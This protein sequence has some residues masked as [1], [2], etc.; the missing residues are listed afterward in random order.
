MPSPALAVKAVEDASACSRPVWAASSMRSS[1]SVFDLIIFSVVRSRSAISRVLAW[2]RNNPK[3]RLAI[4][5]ISARSG[6]NSIREKIIL[7]IFES[8]LEFPGKYNDV[9]QSDLSVVSR[10]SYERLYRKILF[11]EILYGN[12]GD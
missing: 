1:R 3:A 2:H 7:D 9:G 12:I 4:P 5:N 8:F 10:N 11:A 6:E